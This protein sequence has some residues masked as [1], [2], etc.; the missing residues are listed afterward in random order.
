MRYDGE[1]V[2]LLI[3]PSYV[4]ECVGS[5]AVTEAGALSAAG[6]AWSLHGIYRT[7]RGCLGVLGV[8]DTRFGQPASSRR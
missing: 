8:V 6:W 3:S 2:L 5:A 4:Q 7:R 1:Y